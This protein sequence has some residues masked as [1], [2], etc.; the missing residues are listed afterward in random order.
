MYQGIYAGGEDVGKDMKELTDVGEGGTRFFLGDNW[1]LDVDLA[2][3]EKGETDKPVVA[4]RLG[5]LT[6]NVKEGE[7]GILFSA[8]DAQDLAD[9]VSALWNAPHSC[10]EFGMAGRKCVEEEF[11]PGLHYERLLS[12]YG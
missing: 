9:Q 6:E 7:T 3:P 4:S 12:V 1:P 11:S 10:G 5:G 8:G 2:R